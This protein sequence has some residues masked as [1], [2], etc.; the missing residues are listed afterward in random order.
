[1][2]S[3]KELENMNYASLQEV[4]KKYKIKGRWDMRK[5]DLI[6]ALILLGMQ[7]KD[8]D[9]IQFTVEEDKDYTKKVLKEKE[10]LDYIKRVE[11]DT[12]IAFKTPDGKVK[13]AKV[14]N[15]SIAEQKL[16]LI[17]SYGKEYLVDFKDVVWVRTGRRW[18]KG[19]YEL[20]KGKEESKLGDK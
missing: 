8:V 12:L 1:M 15:R 2:Y 9:M 7:G 19:V 18:P 20:L 11:P 6:D 4:A 14:V 17:T 16:K 5:A 10:K 13:S 3:R